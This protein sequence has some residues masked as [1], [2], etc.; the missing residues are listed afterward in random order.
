[1]K[2][3]VVFVCFGVFLLQTSLSTQAMSLDIKPGLWEISWK[4]NLKGNPIPDSE[5]AKMPPEQRAKMAEIFKKRQA[6]SQKTHTT[7]SCL[8][9]DNIDNALS[10]H[11]GKDHCTNTIVS[12]T[13]TKSEFKFQCTGKES[14]S[15][16]MKIE[17]LSRESIRHTVNMK[18]NS[19]KSTFDMESTGKW[20][21]TQ[22]GDVKPKLR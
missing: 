12:D 1:M 17:A 2:I 22:C 3:Q 20:I 7:K 8:T 6:M 19:G 15:G 16:V 4:D 13:S 18:M 9:K 11:E 14:R 10:D 21:S 5:L